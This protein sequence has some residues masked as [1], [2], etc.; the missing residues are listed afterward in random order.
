[1]SDRADVNQEKKKLRAPSPLYRDRN[2]FFMVLKNYFLSPFPHVTK[3]PSASTVTKP[4]SKIH[5]HHSISR[6]G[7]R[8]S[9]PCVSN[10]AC[11]GEGLPYELRCR[12]IPI[13]ESR[14]GLHRMKSSTAIIIYWASKRI[15]CLRVVRRIMNR[16]YLFM[17]RYFYRDLTAW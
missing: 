3:A 13:I 5:N 14:R 7:I 1:V 11:P 6:S 17:R 10:L 4:L 12:A 2:I 8:V 16:C 15:F 9:S